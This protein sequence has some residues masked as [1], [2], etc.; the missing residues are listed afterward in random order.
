MT[1]VLLYC[2]LGIFT[3]MNIFYLIALAKKDNSIVD[4]GWGI[5][6]ILVVIITLNVTQNFTPEALLITAL[7]ILWGLRLAGYIARRNRGRGEDFRYKQ[8]REEWGKTILWRSWLQVFMLQGA[9]MFIIALPVV[10]TIAN[11]KAELGLLEILGA[12]IWGLGFFFEAVGDH[13]MY[14]FKK[15]PENKG[16]VMNS[17]L[18]RYTRHPNYF[19]EAVMWWGIYLIAVDNGSPLLTLVSPVLLT[20]LLLRVSGVTML[21]KKY[22]GNPEYQEYIERTSVFVPMPPKVR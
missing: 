3:Y 20:I 7:V 9:I 17:G 8:W 2:A 14:A 5:G 4:I 1:N 16:K 10:Y 11:A 12:A 13:Q 22:D 6:F 21:E 15:K 19:G 18:W